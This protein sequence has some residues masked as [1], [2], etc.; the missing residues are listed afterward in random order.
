MPR[1]VHEFEMSPTTHSRSF[2][3]N[4]ANF[5]N[6]LISVLSPQQSVAGIRKTENIPSNFFDQIGRWLIGCQ[7]RNIAQQMRPH[8]F[9]ALDL[10]LQHAGAFDQTCSSLK[11]VAA[12]QRVKGKISRSRQTAKQ[13]KYLSKPVV[14]DTRRVRT[15]YRVRCGSLTIKEHAS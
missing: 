1:E 3:I 13:H 8:G 14:P 11:T 12:A 2:E 7:Q 6:C 4:W 10:K 5:L 9:K 15:R